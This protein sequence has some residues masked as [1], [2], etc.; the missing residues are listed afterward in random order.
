MYNHADEAIGQKVVTMT[1]IDPDDDA[2][3]RYSFIQPITAQDPQ[4]N[5]VNVLN[6]YDVSIFHI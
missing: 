2:E 3:L 6:E 1:A 5:E 4:G